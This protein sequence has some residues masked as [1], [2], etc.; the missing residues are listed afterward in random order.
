MALTPAPTDSTLSAVPS[1]KPSNSPP[2]VVCA[3]ILVSDLFVPVLDRIPRPG[4]LV[5]ITPPLYQ[6]GGCAANTS[7]DLASLGVAVR[8]SGRVGNDALGQQVVDELAAGGVDVSGVTRSPDAPTSQTVVLPVAGDDRR[9]LHC[10]GANA[11]YSASDVET[12]A[13]DAALLVIG[14][15]LVLPGLT[16][17]DLEPVIRRLRSRGVRILLD[18]V[19]P[20]DA[21]DPARDIRPLLP[22]VDGFLPNQDEAAAL[23]GRTDPRDQAAQLLAWGC[24]WIVITCGGNGALYADHD[25]ALDVTPLEVDFV[26]GSGAG[27]AF[28][29]GIVAGMLRGWAIEDTLRYASALGASVCRGL[30]CHSTMFSDVEARAAMTGIAVR[31]VPLPAGPA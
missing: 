15:Y 5:E 30:G 12:G 8:V 14:G 28:T 31:E 6:S 29:A 23:T 7:I 16:P 3:G 4:E 24:N 2:E 20:R 25:R 17:A 19:I 18:V 26:D 13:V 11:D 9:F 10:I 22:H 27:D 1:G 21:P